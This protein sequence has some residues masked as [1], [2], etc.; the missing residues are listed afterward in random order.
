MERNLEF[1]QHVQEAYSVLTG[2]TMVIIDLNGEEITNVSGF[3]SLSKLLYDT[4]PLKDNFKN[5]TTSLKSVWQP[6]FLDNRIGLKY[7]VSP[8][9]VDGRIVYYLFSGFILEQS[10]RQFV[11]NYVNKNFSEVNG[12]FEAL[13]LAPET[14]IQ[15]KNEKMKNIRK[16]NQVVETHLTSLKENEHQSFTFQCMDEIRSGTLKTSEYV[17]KIY[18]KHCDLHFLGLAM[19]KDEA[20]YYLQLMHGDN[21]ERLI[22]TTFSIGEGFVGQTIAAEKFQFWNE[23]ENDPRINYFHRSQLYPKSLFCAPIFDNNKVIGSLFGGSFNDK[24]EEALII[25]MEQYSS[26]LSML[27]TMQSQKSNLQNHLMELSTF[28]EIFKVITNVKDVKRVLFILLDISMNIVRGPFC[29]VVFKPDISS[30]KVDIVSRG[31]SGA[32]IN[33]YCHSVA[34]D[35][36]IHSNRVNRNQI[37]NGKTE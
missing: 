25:K 15:E 5:S 1:L 16:F 4:W 9:R 14:T 11:Q 27:F 32:Q 13:K 3:N 37:V 34:S 2:L 18:H 24:L 26:L 35:V 28:N 33:D 10:S 22:G 12:L 21:T 17:A 30:S 36:F 31:L 7:I 29:C 8:I 23:V 6:V 19:Q 20:E